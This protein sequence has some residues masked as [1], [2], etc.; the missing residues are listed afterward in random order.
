MSGLAVRTLGSGPALVMVPGWAMHTGMWG[1]FAQALARHFTLILVD[2]PGHGRVPGPHPWTLEALVADLARVHREA[3]W[4]GWSLGGQLLVALASLFPER[5]RGLILLASNPKF[6]ADGDWPGMDGQI[7]ETFKRRLI[8]DPGSAVKRFLGLICHGAP[9]SV[10]KK[11]HRLWQTCP[12]ADPDALIQG[13]NLLGQLDL[14][15]NLGQVNCPVAIISGQNDT[16][17]PAAV[18]QRLVAQ[19]PRVRLVTVAAGGHIPFLVEP[20]PL[21]DWIRTTFS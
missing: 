8:Q 4:L 10:G 3:F 14:R 11:A 19:L 15:A 6:V 18:Q 16:L 20:A 17:V 7:F 13:L 21:A 1:E 2:L 12:H 5:V 9:R